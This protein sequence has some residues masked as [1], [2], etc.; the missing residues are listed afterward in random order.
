MSDKPIPYV[1][2]WAGVFGVGP[3]ARIIVVSGEQTSVAAARQIQGILG[4]GS[5]V[6]AGALFEVGVAPV[7][8]LPGNPLPWKFR[9]I[10]P[11]RK[12]NGKTESAPQCI[13]DLQSQSPS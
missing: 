4:S 7:D 12:P 1:S 6:A 13:Q 9:E 11:E 5:H 3:G 10:P 8:D 2:G